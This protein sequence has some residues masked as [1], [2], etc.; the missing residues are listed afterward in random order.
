MNTEVR[1]FTHKEYPEFV[2][3]KCKSPE[4]IR[5]QLTGSKIHLWH[6]ITGLT[7]EAVEMFIAQTDANA[8]EEFG[9]MLFYTVGI[10]NELSLYGVRVEIPTDSYNPVS[11]IDVFKMVDKICS[12]LKR[13]VI[14]NKEVELQRVGKDITTLISMLYAAAGQLFHMQGA[15]LR[16]SNMMKLDKR[17]ANGYSD[18]EANARADKA[19]EEK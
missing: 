14:Y 12:E 1:K 15:E 17:Y 8:K 19:G 13:F 9:D 2:A 7:G 18:A 4:E 11:S 5:I 10:A 16:H 3:Y 6:M